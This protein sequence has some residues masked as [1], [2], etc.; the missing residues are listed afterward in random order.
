MTQTCT[1]QSAILCLD[2]LLHGN[3]V[4]AL[5]ADRYRSTRTSN[6]ILELRRRGGLIIDCE[7]RETA[8]GSWYGVY[9][10]LFLPENAAKARNLL[11]NLRTEQEQTKAERA[12]DRAKKKG[13]GGGQSKTLDT[14]ERSEG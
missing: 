9:R 10:L 4:T 7:R 12:A 11:E 1:I 14:L 3:E 2:A 6:I 13:A 5:K 8:S